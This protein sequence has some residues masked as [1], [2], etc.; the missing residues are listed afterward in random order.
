[1]DTYT[2]LDEDTRDMI[3]EMANIGTGS[4]ATSLSTIMGCPVEIEVPDL[5]LLAYKELAAEMD[6]AEELKTG[7]LVEVS[8]DIRG[9][10]LFLLNETFTVD[11]LDTVLGSA[12]RT[13]T[14]L[15]TLEQSVLC[16]LGNIMCG[17]Y[18]R[19]MSQLTQTDNTVS[20]PDLCIDMGGAILGCALSRF[21]QIG[22]EILMIKNRL[23]IGEKTFN[24]HIFFVPE[25][26]SLIALQEKLWE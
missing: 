21:L 10:F 23:E 15:D 22:E 24:G 16:E 17:S 13:L 3:A 11:L 26:S 18:I 20:V 4:A 6:A 5:K 19:A 9:I 7:I 25:L 1:M 14:D 2:Q 12:Q 8:G